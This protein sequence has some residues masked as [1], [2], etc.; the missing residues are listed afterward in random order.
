MVPEHARN[1]VDKL[2]NLDTW[3][4][5]PFGADKL[6]LYNFLRLVQNP[7]IESSSVNSRDIIQRK[8]LALKSMAGIAWCFQ[9]QVNYKIEI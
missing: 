9:I 4:R 8:L 6:I 1:H 2:N 5:I 7:G 3:H